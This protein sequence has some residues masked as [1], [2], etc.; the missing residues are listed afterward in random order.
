MVEHKRKA[1]EELEHKLFEMPSDDE[2]DGPDLNTPQVLRVFD[3]LAT[4]LNVKSRLMK[5]SCYIELR[6][7]LIAE[8]AKWDT[9]K[10]VNLSWGMMCE[11]FLTGSPGIGKTSF[12][13]WLIKS[14]LSRG[15]QVIFGCREFKGN[16]LR[17]DTQ[18]Q[19]T[20]R[21]NLR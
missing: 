19:T 11:I 17:F 18:T 6:Q 20:K 7:F 2:I 13:A 12:L 5:R 10:Q 1:V 3:D 14:L 16:G 8:K 9:Q 4:K 15:V 21:D